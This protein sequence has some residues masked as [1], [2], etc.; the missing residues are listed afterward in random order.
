M[1]LWPILVSTGLSGSI[2]GVFYYIVGYIW[3]EI[4]KTLQ[5]SLKIKYNEKV[6]KMVQVFMKDKG[7]MT[8]GGTL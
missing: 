3:G 4:S 6:F 5:T 2:M 8:S 1:T 7:Y